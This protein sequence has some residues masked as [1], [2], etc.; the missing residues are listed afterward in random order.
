MRWVLYLHAQ[1]ATPSSSSLLLSSLELSDT[2]VYEPYIRAL[3]GTPPKLSRQRCSCRRHLTFS[4][5]ARPV[6]L[7]ITMIKWIQTSRLS[8]KTPL[9]ALADCDAPVQLSTLCREPARG[10]VG[11]G[12]MS[13]GDGGVRTKTS[14]SLDA[15]AEG[16]C[17]ISISTFFGAPLLSRH[18]GDAPAL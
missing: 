1:A 5:G 16:T 2:H 15:R 10:P 3:L 13:G 12:A 4:H 9:S 14:P 11:V 7:I 8:I 6:H 18:K 17:A